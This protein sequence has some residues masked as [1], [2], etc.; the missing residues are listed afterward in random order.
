[1]WGYGPEI[2]GSWG[3]IL[4]HGFVWLVV[5]ALLGTAIVLLM[6][7]TARAILA[8]IFSRN[9]MREARS[10]ATNISKRSV[11]SLDKSQPREWS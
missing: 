4:F 3:W 10:T 1:M 6:R 5:W 9:V 2:M 11:T 7:Q 8:S